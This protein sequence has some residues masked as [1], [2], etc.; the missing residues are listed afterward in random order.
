MTQDF[1]GTASFAVVANETYA[2]GLRHFLETEMGL[3]CTFS[4]ARRAGVK[5]DND[6]VR[7]AIQEKPPLI[8]FGS[9][10]ERMYLRRERRARACTFRPRSPARSSGATPARP[11]WATAGATYIIQEVCNAL[12]DALFN[13][14]PLATR[15]RQGGCHA[16]AS[17]P[18]AA[19][20]GRCAAGA[21]GPGGCGAGAG[22]HFGGEAAARRGG[23][24]G[25]GRPGRITS[26][27]SGCRRPRA[28]RDGWSPPDAAPP[29]NR[30]MRNSP[31]KIGRKWAPDAGR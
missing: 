19:L 27:S 7:E 30:I 18:R 13:I 8:M 12:F 29:R 16:V 17:A 22:A 26:A 11:S 3:P 15:S 2:R 1:F 28:R 9:F 31:E 24:R 20:D 5:P 21:G 4:F 23:A 25:A 14:L 6:A 10:N